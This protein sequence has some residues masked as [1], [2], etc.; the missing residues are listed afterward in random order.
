[1]GCVLTRQ[2]PTANGIQSASNASKYNS[3]I[4]RNRVDAAT[5]LHCAHSRLIAPK[6]NLLSAGCVF[7]EMQ[8]WALLYYS[9]LSESISICAGS[10][11]SLGP[12]RQLQT[13]LNDAQIVVR[14]EQNNSRNM[15]VI[16]KVVLHQKT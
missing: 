2:R 12:N 11:S 3:H 9:T 8:E 1:M 4:A 16:E 5:F 14:Y 15:K 6:F 7:G 10:T 13:L